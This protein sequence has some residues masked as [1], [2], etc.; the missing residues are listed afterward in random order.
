MNSEREV[1][2][3]EFVSQMVTSCVNE[4]FTGSF[5]NANLTANEAK[6]LKACYVSTAKRLQTA[7]K[8]MGLDCQLN[9]SFT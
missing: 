2:A 5:A 4:C 7:G 8:A 1:H 9:N 3:K 6:C